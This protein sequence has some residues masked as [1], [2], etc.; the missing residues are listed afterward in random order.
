[1]T[2]SEGLRNRLIKKTKSQL[3]DE[4]VELNG[5]LPDL[6]TLD[7]QTTEQMATSGAAAILSEQAL[8][9]S[10]SILMEA[11]KIAKLGHWVWD[12]IER[13]CIYAS[14]EYANIRG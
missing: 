7:N 8:Q 4:I 10:Q 6:R 13:T 1:M 5:L 12:E 2:S 3:V 14:E 9:Q 11:V